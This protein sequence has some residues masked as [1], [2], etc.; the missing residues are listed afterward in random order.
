MTV[1]VLT[2]LDPRWESAY[3]V[4]IDSSREGSVV[5]RCADVAELLSTAEAGL[6][7]VALLSATVPGLDR[8]AVDRLRRCGVQPCGAQSGGDEADERRLRQLGVEAWLP[9]DAAPGEVDDL[10]RSA[11]AA[12]SGE[13]SGAE[14][15]EALVHAGARGAGGPDLASGP[16]EHAVGGAARAEGPGPDLPDDEPDADEP[17]RR[18]TVVAVW[19]PTGAPGRT[20]VA[21]GL[22][23]EF[24]AAGV[25]VLLIDADTYGASVAQWLSLLDEAPGLAAAA[26]SSEQGSLDLPGLARHAPEVSSGFRVL[27]GLPRPDRWTEVRSAAMGQVLELSRQLATVVVVDCGF[28]IEDDE[29]LSYDTL[30]PR[31]NVTTLTAIEEADELLVVGAADPVGLQ[32]LV[33]AVQS[34]DVLP[35]A[36][37]LVVVNR[38]R[39]SAVG[40]RPEQRIA[41]ALGRF[42]GL[43][44]PVFLP[45][46]IEAA[47]GALLAGRTLVEHAPTAPLRQALT[48]LAR[49]LTAYPAETASRGRRR[50]ARSGA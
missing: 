32:R 26:R 40:A 1:R 3:A 8:D 18:G 6:A 15:D 28:S 25:S 30:A 45:H 46:D 39:S 14:A 17:R 11:V 31:R 41:E 49:R 38:V 37:P 27:T 35:C 20:T 34:L 4:L 21:V 19:G 42:A 24:A 2:A 13:G 22:A 48:A 43:E 36:T 44:E 9:L 16:G 12:R 5:R 29:E 7:D 47:D 50:L 33:R 10:L 23:A